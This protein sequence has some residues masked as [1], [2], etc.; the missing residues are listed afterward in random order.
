MARLAGT[1]AALFLC[2]CCHRAQAGNVPDDSYHVLP[3]R[4]TIACTADIVPPGALEIEAGYLAR[5]VPPR[6]FVH[7]APLLL[8]LSLTGWLQVQLASGGRVFTS[9]D[10]GRQLRYVDDIVPGVKVR[11][12]KQNEYR[13]S[14]SISA[15]VGVPSW[16]PHPDFAFALDASF[17]GYVSKD[18]G[19]VHIDV[20]GGVNALEFE[21]HASWQPF[22]TLAIGFALPY[23]LGSFIET[24][25][26]ADAGA[27][28][29]HEG[30][31][32]TGLTFA[33]RPWLMFDAGIDRSAYPSRRAYS[34]FTGVT[35]IPYDF[36][37]TDAERRAR[38][39]ATSARAS[40]LH[41]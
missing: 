15:H 2:L 1:S 38:L 14:V 30:G 23:R 34:L 4:P 3:C 20:N 31:V 16:D 19:V 40:L 41:R 11:F 36:W 10:V 22:V 6:G 37:D 27:I 35:V 21:R 18:L 32:L 24:Y 25:A 5:R 29:P 12:L 33:P 7:D 17:W 39:S 9:G 13:P 8:K 28:A 26:F